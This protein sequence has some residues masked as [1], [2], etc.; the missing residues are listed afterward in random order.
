MNKHFRF[1]GTSFAR[2]G[3]LGVSPSAV[4]RRAGLAPGLLS[5]PRVLLKTVELF[6]LWSA[7]GEVSTNPAIGL[8]LGT[9]TKT[10]QFT[11]TGLAALSCEN[12]GEAVNQMAR[13]KQLTAPRKF[14]NTNTRGSG[15]F[16]SAGCSQR[17]LSRPS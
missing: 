14:C 8:L 1:S 16:S 6:A 17:K 7:I 12:F 3:E 13:Y 9:K 15:A 10:E 11:S 4:L 2:V 5:E